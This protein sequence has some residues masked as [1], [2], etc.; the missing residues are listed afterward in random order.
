M[1]PEAAG[2][3]PRR[4]VMAARPVADSAGICRLIWPGET[5]S[6][7][8]AGVAPEE[9][10]TCTVMSTSA[11]GHGVPVA[12]AVWAV[13]PSP[14][15]VTREPGAA[16]ATLADAPDRAVRYPPPRCACRVDIC[17]RSTVKLPAGCTESA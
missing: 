6:R 5:Y 4:T 10:V 11:D 16:R 1:V 12:R 17:G 9:S 3:L 15:I 14:Y 13:N 2:E 8:A 7:P